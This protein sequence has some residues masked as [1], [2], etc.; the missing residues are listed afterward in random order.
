MLVRP[1]DRGVLLIG[2]PSH[3]WISGQLAR[4]WGND[5]FGRLEPYE[6]VCL[7][8]EQ[9]DIGMAEWDLRP[10]RNPDTGF[11]RSF[12][13]MPIPVHLGLWTQGPRRLLRQ[14]RY[15]ALLTSMH[16]TRLYRLRD[17]DR[18]PGP[19]ANAIRDYLTAEEHFQQE[20]I[21][22]LK[23]DPT[24]ADSVAPPNL[25]RNSQLIWTWD[26]LSLALCLDWAPWTAKN[27]PTAGVAVDLNVTPG[28]AP[29]QLVLD[30]WP[31]NAPTTVYCEGQ[32]LRAP[33]GSDDA[34]AEALA[35]APWERL[36]LDLRPRSD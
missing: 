19:E 17:L 21:A 31:L 3:A 25:D 23:A 11:P 8:A 6:E 22:T 36:A 10:E 27:V 12:M 34:L 32:R 2:Q 13:E 24:T 20:L 7:A 16:G 26:S 18:L 29:N 33:T 15:A 1:D 9:H 5:R 28:D 4:A 35:T 30:P 14:S